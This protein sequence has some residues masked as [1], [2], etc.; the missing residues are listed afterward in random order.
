L[1]KRIGRSGSIKPHK[2]SGTRT[3]A[4]VRSPSVDMLPLHM[5]G[6][7]TNSKQKLADGGLRAM[8]LR[9]PQYASIG[10]IMVQ[11]TKNTTTTNDNGQLPTV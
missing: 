10:Q 9:W 6:F 1:G 3:V 11:P 4:I 2:V 7:V 5:R 8:D